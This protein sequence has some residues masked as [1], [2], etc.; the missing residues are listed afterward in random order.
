MAHLVL[1]G[2]VHRD[3]E[4]HDKLLSLLHEEHPDCLTLEMSPYAVRYRRKNRVT[5]AKRI[6]DTLHDLDRETSTRGFQDFLAHPAIQDTIALIDF[7]YE[8]MAAS[9]FSESRKVPFHCID[10]SD[11]S[12][13]KISWIEKELITTE[14][15]R[16]LIDLDPNECSQRTR[17]EYRL[18]SMALH[19]H[20]SVIRQPQNHG[21]ISQRDRHMAGR[22]RKLLTR[23]RCRKLM[24]IGGW[25]HLLD[26]GTNDTL[27]ER[28]SDLRP[29]RRLLIH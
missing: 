14:N 22:I 6:L 23:L 12:L 16:T 8:Y 4:G 20:G 3:P 25:E 19:P 13:E 28:L 10:R 29:R 17:Q 1:V 18:A 2:T 26:H 9:T 24:H 21:E 15:L 7:P 5:L 11:Y 27:F